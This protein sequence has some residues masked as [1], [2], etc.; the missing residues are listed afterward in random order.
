M[1]YHTN[2]DEVWKAVFKVWGRDEMFV[3]GLGQQD[4]KI[5]ILRR[6][7][8]QRLYAQV[9]STKVKE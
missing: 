9:V 3:L 7:I 8:R 4:G 2:K 6:S 5:A 1:N